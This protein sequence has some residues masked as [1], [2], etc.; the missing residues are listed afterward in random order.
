MIQGP[1][2]GLTASGT[3]SNPMKTDLNPHGAVITLS[4]RS[5]MVVNQA[6]ARRTPII[7]FRLADAGRWRRCADYLFGGRAGR[8]TPHAGAISPRHQRR[9]MSA[10]EEDWQSSAAVDPHTEVD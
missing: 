9:R 3:D 4:D 8:S 7:R 5:H 10:N 2:P 1:E 6:N